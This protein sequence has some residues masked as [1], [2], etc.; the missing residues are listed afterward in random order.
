M[1]P[2]PHEDPIRE[3]LEDPNKKLE[4]QLPAELE[5]QLV[6]PLNA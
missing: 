5:L 6:T 1:T 2:K 4:E 3:Q